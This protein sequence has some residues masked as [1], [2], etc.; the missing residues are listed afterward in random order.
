[1]TRLP[2]RMARAGSPHPPFDQ[3]FYPSGPLT[4]AFESAQVSY[5]DLPV[6]LYNTGINQILSVAAVRGHRLLHF[7]MADLHDRSGEPA[8]DVSVL[9]LEP[10]WDGGDPLYAHR[11]LRVV[12]RQTVLLKDAQL[13]VLR[14]DDIRTEE[15]PNLEIL[16]RATV[17]A[18]TLE[19][20][21]ATLSTTDKY[22]PLERGPQLPHPVTFPASTLK[23]ALEAIERVPHEEPY[24]VLKDRYGYGCGAQVHR[25]SFD[26]PEL[27][28]RV[29]GHLEAYGHVLIQEYCAEV[30][31]GDIV[32]TF[33]DD[34]L[35]G[36]LRRVPAEGEW[37]TNFST[38]ADQLGYNLTPEQELIA[39]ALKRSFPE[40]RLASVDMLSSGRILEI[41][42]FPGGE[43]FLRNYGISLGEV[44]M[45][46]LQ[47]ELLGTGAARAAPAALSWEAEKAPRFPTGAR[48]PEI[49][50][51][52][53]RHEGQREVYDVF[54]GDRYRLGIGDLI[55]FVPRSPEYIVSIPHAGVFV[56]EAFR[57][58][59]HLG[60]DALVEIDL[61]SDLCYEMAE[62]M[63]VRCE[64]APF[65]VDM[66]RAR[67]GAEEGELPRHLTNP[68]HE[69]YD[70]TDSLMLRRPYSA[71]EQEQVLAYYDVYHGLL[72]ALIDRMRRERGYA[73]LFDCHSMTSTG[74]G[75]VEDEGED[76]ASFVAG[77]LE[78]TS[79]HGA[80][81]DAFM[82]TLR[83]QSSGH[84]LGLTVAR[85]VPYS[86]GFITR[87]HHDPDAHIHVVQ[88]EVAMDTYM[89]EVVATPSKRYALKK[90]RLRIV[91][92]AVQAAFRAAAEEAER[93]YHQSPGGLV[94]PD[95]ERP[96]L[97]L[98]GP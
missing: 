70:V 46:R 22:A 14:A 89:Y 84:G 17:H 69:Y 82:T 10:G 73:L 18:K 29:A 31:E 94:Q 26:D 80:I 24:F 28:D 1:M 88:L 38:G 92:R 63:H 9:E 40:C 48:W 85:D 64:L 44:V 81:I 96:E 11:H 25:L 68:A 65:F 50:E 3:A 43:G 86:G 66:N 55:E 56:P 74:L 33:F 90:P 2:A 27:E 15:T 19:S 77:T 16:R 51:L 45:D 41:N 83:A 61:Y 35:I 98:P 97:S 49:E 87:A 21:E 95:R 91:R 13:F 76:R 72:E 20:V 60:E 7:S 78:G 6:D 52:Y 93:I 79:A 34:E 57:D 39:R 47:K 12:D 58:R 36:A 54:S 23:E 62:G 71:Q 53:A 8:A 75:R 30:A 37:K 67:E 42:A 5:S 4:I 59:F 32:V